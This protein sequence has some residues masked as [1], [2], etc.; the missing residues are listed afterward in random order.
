MPSARQTCG[1]N[2]A[3][4]NVMTSCQAG[5]H[6]MC[7][8]S[9]SLMTYAACQMSCG[10]AEMHEQSDA[11]SKGIK[12]HIV[13]TSRYMCVTLNQSLYPDTITQSTTALA[14][15]HANTR[16]AHSVYKNAYYRPY[17]ANIYA[18]SV[19]I[20]TRCIYAIPG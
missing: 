16:E 5:S 15:L 2:Y 13:I 4:I 6:G 3:F 20:H 14:L 12:H 7:R 17:F 10:P 1:S 18:C 11:P 9:K 8:L 19:H